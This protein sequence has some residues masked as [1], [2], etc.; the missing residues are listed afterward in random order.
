M[1]LPQRSSLLFM[2]FG[3]MCAIGAAEQNPATPTIPLCQGLTIEGRSR[4]R[5]VVL[6]LHAT[7]FQLGP[8]AD[9]DMSGGVTLDGARE[10]HLS[11]G[12]LEFSSCQFGTVLRQWRTCARGMASD[13]VSK[14]SGS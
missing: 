8:S 1:A 3:C 13:E 6:V 11:I 9:I 10:A 2:V 5:R 7:A 14:R 4:N 12:F